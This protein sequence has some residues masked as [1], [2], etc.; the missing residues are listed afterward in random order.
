MKI[1]DLQNYINNRTATVHSEGDQFTVHCFYKG[2]IDWNI[3]ILTYRT[4]GNALH[5]AM[6]YITERIGK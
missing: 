3:G 4:M 1:Y 2:H 6:N 5:V